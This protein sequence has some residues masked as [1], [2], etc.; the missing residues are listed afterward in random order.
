LMVATGGGIGGGAGEGTGAPTGE[1]SELDEDDI[2]ELKKDG[3][4]LN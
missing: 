1:G 2:T 4:K 3:I